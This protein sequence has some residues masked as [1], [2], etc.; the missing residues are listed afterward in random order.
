[1]DPFRVFRFQVLFLEVREVGLQE[2]VDKET[3]RT[4]FHEIYRIGAEIQIVVLFFGG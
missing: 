3:I 2:I 4:Y 1:M